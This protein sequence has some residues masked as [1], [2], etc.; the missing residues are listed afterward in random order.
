[1][2]KPLPRLTQPLVRDRLPDGSRGPQRPA[3]WDEALERA[4]AGLKTSKQRHGPSSVG[5]FSCSK[6][7]NEVNYLA[8]KFI[9]LA[10]GSNNIDSC[11]RT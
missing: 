10:I 3:S 1:M 11:N 2:H 5:V 7:T 6:A 4:A 9:R 8:Q